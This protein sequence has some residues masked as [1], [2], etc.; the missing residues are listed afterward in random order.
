MRK[1]F[2]FIVDGQIKPKQRPFVTRKKTFTP[3]ETLN[4]EKLIKET[5]LKQYKNIT[6]NKSGYGVI[7]KIFVKKPKKAKY[8]YPA[9]FDI[10]NVAKTVLDALNGVIWIDDSQVIQLLVQKSFAE[11]SYVEITVDEI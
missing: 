5:F 1:E 4:S 6:P 10:D 11:K 8:F 3:T 9:K 7:I 2:K